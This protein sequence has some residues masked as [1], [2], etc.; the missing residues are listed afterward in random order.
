MTITFHVRDFMLI[1][2]IWFVG[3]I[4]AFAQDKSTGVMAGLAGLFGAMAWTF[5][6]FFGT[7]VYLVVR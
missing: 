1:G 3:C 4:I 2:G 7:L 5:V 6:C